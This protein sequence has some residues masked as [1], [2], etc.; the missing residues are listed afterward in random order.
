MT[1]PSW[2]TELPRLDLRGYGR[3]PV[4]NRRK[5][6]T[7]VGP[8][9]YRP[10][11]TLM[12]DRM[13]IPIITDLACRQLLWRF[14]REELQEGASYF[15]LPDP[16]IDG[17]PLLDEN[18]APILNVDGTPVLNSKILLCAMTEPPSEVAPIGRG[19]TFELTLDILP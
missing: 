14:W 10:R 12:T 19:F 17:K 7:D 13:S 4:D 18:F 3:A 11:T 6:P 8:P 9:E 1:Y 2:P 15:T 5:K 16:V